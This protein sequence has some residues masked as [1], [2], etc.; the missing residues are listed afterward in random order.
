MPCFRPVTCYQPLAGGSI[1][2]H[3]V[4]NCRT[5]TIKCG[6]CIGCRLMRKNAWALRCLMESKQHEHSFFGTFTYG[7]DSVPM[8]GSLQYSDMQLMFKRLR[9]RL[10]PF[11]YFVCGEYGEQLSR[12]HYHVLFFGT[13]FPDLKRINSMA[14]KSPIYSAPVLTE[15]WPQ[16]FHS[17][18][19][20]SLASARYCA[21]YTVDKINGKAAEDHYSRVDDSTGEIV[22]VVPEFARMSLKPGIGFSWLAKYWRDI[23]CAGDGAIL[24]PGGERA[25]VPRYF[26]KA[27]DSIDEVRP[28]FMDEVEY[29][30]FLS[31]Q[32]RAADNTP[33]RL[34]V[35]EQCELARI[36]FN[37]E[38]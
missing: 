12:P 19:H 4:K 7:P 24:L 6:Q 30:A 33:E 29:K 21:S 1:V 8:H 14:S 15:C 26:A 35:R 5:L 28:T 31:F 13:D 36:K 20:I 27:M 32:S 10:G 38:R 2:F 3:E 9:G 16:G 25:A 17:L 23:Y 37:A 34:A 22:S 11:R 18:G